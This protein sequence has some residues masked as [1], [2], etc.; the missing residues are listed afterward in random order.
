MVKTYWSSNCGTGQLSWIREY[1]VGIMIAEDLLHIKLIDCAELYD[2]RC[3]AKFL[4]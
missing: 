2:W 3:E 1:S 4:L